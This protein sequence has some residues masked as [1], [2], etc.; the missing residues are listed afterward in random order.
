MKAP[1]RDESL[2]AAWRVMVAEEIDARDFV[3]VDECGTHTS[4]ARV[5]GYSPRGERVHSE[6]PRTRPVQQ[7]ELHIQHHTCVLR[8]GVLDLCAAC[9]RS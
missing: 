4:L 3:F 1:K 5:Y 6:V 8:K 7:H 2:R 9:P